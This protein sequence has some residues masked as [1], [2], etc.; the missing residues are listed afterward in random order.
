MAQL[1]PPIEPYAHGLMDVGAGHQV[2]WEECGNPAGQPAL[3]IHGGPGSGASPNWR[4][5]FD[6][7]RYRV[8]LFDQRGCGRSTP[9][10][11]DSLLALAANT[12]ADLLADMEQL[13]ALRRI[14]QWLLFAG[15]W[16]VTLGLAYA[17]E[18]ADRVRST[19]FFSI[20]A[21]TRQELDWIT[22]HAGRFFP[23][24]WA[25]FCRGVPVADRDGD[26]ADAYAR[27]LASPD[28]EVREKAARDWCAWEVAHVAIRPG[29]KPSPRYED[30]RFRLAF[31]RIV[32]HYW[33]H[34][35]WVEGL[36]LVGGAS[37]LAAIPALLVH[38]GLDISSPPDVAWRLSQSWPGARLTLIDNAGHGAGEPG[39]TEILVQATDLF[40][41]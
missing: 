30:P 38:G 20:T 28:A 6:P 26:L 36:D 35:C 37:Q 8:I 40:A 14:D 24:A 17:Q 12:T 31:A 10:A 2:Y 5:Y 16:G 21:G 18:H 3:V 13:R 19:V 15:S 1:Y 4:R 23:E 9:H 7:D 41:G 32:T 29:Q 34:G 22:R 39:M 25:E 33:R 11:A 27:L